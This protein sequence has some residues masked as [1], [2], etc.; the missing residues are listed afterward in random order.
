[1]ISGLT[2]LHIREHRRCRFIEDAGLGHS[3]AAGL[4]D[5]PYRSRPP[6][7]RASP[8]AGRGTPVWPGPRHVSWYLSAVARLASDSRSR[9]P[10][11]T[12]CAGAYVESIG[13]V[14]GGREFL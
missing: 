14:L 3:K 8:T 6:A 10:P 12:D 2:S 5:V 7:R 4:E 1:M 11:A 13:L 9:P